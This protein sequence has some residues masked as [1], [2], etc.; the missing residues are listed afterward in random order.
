MAKYTNK[1]VSLRR[2]QFIAAWREHAPEVTFAQMSLEQFEEG[3]QSPQ[4][5]RKLMN[6]A[7]TKLAGLKLD[8]DKADREMNDKM[9]IIGHAIRGNPAYGEDCAFYRSLGFVPRSERKTGRKGKGPAGTPPPS[10][11]AA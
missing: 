8:R 6:A 3:T 7:Q 1:T 9:L 4:E 2:E 11:D 10:A 5:V